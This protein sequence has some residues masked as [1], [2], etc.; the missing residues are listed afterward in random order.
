MDGISGQEGRT[1]SGRNKQ[2]Q[3]IQDRVMEIVGLLLRKIMESPESASRRNR[4]IK[5]LE[6]RG[7]ER[8]E[9]DAAIELVMAVPEILGSINARRGTEPPAY[10]IF[11]EY[12]QYKLGVTVRGRLIQYRAL[13]LLTELELEEVLVHLLSVEGG[14]VGLADLHQALRK[15]VGDSERL[16]II[17][18]GIEPGAINAALN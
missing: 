9:I 10:R 4:I 14:E 15:V 2:S 1:M 18:P 16:M 12:E 3:N 13:G 6:R 11:S 8:G 5:G 7:Y 17:L